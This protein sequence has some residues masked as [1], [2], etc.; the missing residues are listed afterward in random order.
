MFQFMSI[1]CFYC[2]RSLGSLLGVEV[3]RGCACFAWLGGGGGVFNAGSD[4]RGWCACCDGGAG[5]RTL[6]DSA[7]RGGEHAM[8]DWAGPLLA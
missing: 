6:Q 2:T 3:G 7:C 1:L 5:T 4:E 8:K